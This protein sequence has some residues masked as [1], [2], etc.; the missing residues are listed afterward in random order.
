MSVAIACEQMRTVVPKITGATGRNPDHCDQPISTYCSHPRPDSLNERQA[1]MHFR[2]QIQHETVQRG[3]QYLVHFTQAWN[4]PSIV[5]HGLLSRADLH[6]R[7]LGTFTSASHR[8]DEKDEAIS[9]S[10]SAIN[11]KM[12]KA[13]QKTCGQ[14]A[15]IVLLLDPNIL[16]T[17]NCRFC[18]RNAARRAMKEHRGRLDGPWGFAKMFSDDMPPPQFQGESYRTETSIPDCLTTRPDAEVQ[19]FG[20]IAP[21]TIVHAW[22]DRL[23]VAEAVQVELIRLP[24]QERDVSVREFMPRFSNGY[25][26]WG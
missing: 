26:E 15:W 17:H 24:G 14:T 4:L 2:E 16:W 3:I 7:G 12:F 18:S 19:V 20:P 11:Y 23:N 25:S 5:K 8:L 21:E 1:G 22:V 6:A 9:V 10:I 13:K